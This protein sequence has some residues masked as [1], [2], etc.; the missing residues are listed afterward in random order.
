MI[1]ITETKEQ[2]V[3]TPNIK[4]IEEEGNDNDLLDY[5]HSLSQI[6]E[7]ARYIGNGYEVLDGSN[8]SRYLNPYS[9]LIGNTERVYYFPEYSCKDIVKELLIEKKP[10]TFIYLTEYSSDDNGD[11]I[12]LK[13][14]LSNKE[15]V[16][17][18][19]Q[20]FDGEIELFFPTMPFDP[21]WKEHC[22][23]FF[24]DA[25]GYN[26][27][28]THINRLQEGK[29]VELNDP[30]LQK[31]IDLI[32]P[33]FWADNTSLSFQLVTPSE[34]LLNIWKEYRFWDYSI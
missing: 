10:I 1:D 34:R 17:V 6:L 21:N 8:F 19:A 29:N 22:T 16:P 26:W 12:P 14:K 27:G 13:E 31:M 24:F 5:Y 33:D 28:S 2:L 18:I 32:S 3:I 9:E 15:T 11:I 23:S 20:E 7:D 30:R 25:G 4:E